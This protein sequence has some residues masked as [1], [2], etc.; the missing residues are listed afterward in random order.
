LL[1]RGERREDALDDQLLLEAARACSLG[2]EDLRH[3]PRAEPL[4]EEEFPE[5]FRLEGVRHVR[6]TT[7]A[8]RRLTARENP[9]N[10]REQ[11]RK[12]QRDEQRRPQ[13]E[14]D[15]PVPPLDGD[16]ARKSARFDAGELLEEQ[17]RQSSEDEHGA[18]RDQSSRQRSH[19]VRVLHTRHLFR[20]RVLLGRRKEE[21]LLDA[22]PSAEDHQQAVQPGRHPSRGGKP[23]DRLEEALVERIGGASEAA[24]RLALLDQPPAL[25][26][27]VVELEEP[28]RQLHARDVELEALGHARVIPPQPCHRGHGRGPVHEKEGTVPAQPGLEREEDAEEE[29][30]VGLGRPR[31]EARGEDALAQEPR[32]PVEREIHARVLGEGLPHRHPP[33][34]RPQVHLGVAPADPLGTRDDARR[35]HADLLQVGE[36]GRVALLL[37]HHPVVLEH[38]ELRVVVLR[39]LAV[40]EGL[41]DLEDPLPTVGEEPLHGEFRRGVKPESPSTALR[42]HLRDEAGLEAVDVQLHAGGRD[43]E[44]SFDFVETLLAEVVA[45][46]PVEHLAGSRRRLLSQRAA[47]ACALPW[48][49]RLP[50]GARWRYKGPM[51]LAR[52]ARLVALVL[53]AAACASSPE[54]AA[55]IDPRDAPE[56]R[57]VVPPPTEEDRELARRAR[58]EAARHVA[59]QAELVWRLWV[60]EEPPPAEE[61]PE[62]LFAPE[63]ARAVERVAVHEDD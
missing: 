5:E 19:R 29:V 36:E 4:E 60:G 35:P 51:Q 14:V 39:D 22:R 10:E 26:R 1:I 38:G 25:L 37:A 12:Q 56:P 9:E 32:V 59:R 61:P 16:V 31:V 30:V 6:P 52:P 53:C 28:V 13:G 23:S 47:H 2:T 15:P 62:F 41:G 46:D 34:R 7:R 20:H 40:P 33:P 24:P 48:S 54:P 55:T 11:N 8:D 49:A 21:H 58:E 27:L 18:D 45:D 42:P 57:R 63:T 43:E 3:A 17:E 50:T 44:G